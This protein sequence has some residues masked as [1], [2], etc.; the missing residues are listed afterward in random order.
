MSASLAGLLTLVMVSSV[1][2]A[3]LAVT[4]IGSLDTSGTFYSSWWYTNENPALSG[5]AGANATVTVDIDGAGDNTTADINGNWYY[6][7]TTLTTG[8]HLI[9]ITS[10]SEVATFNLTIGADAST[11][12]STTTATASATLP[13]TLPDS[14]VGDYAIILTIIGLGAIGLGG[15][16]FL[17]AKE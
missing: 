13:T 14:G 12:T 15:Y 5:T 2:A 6:S 10:E 4:S 17:S 1:H 11:S 9:T 16:T 3:A 7:P 8:D